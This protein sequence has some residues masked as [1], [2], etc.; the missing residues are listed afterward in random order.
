MADNYLF[1]FVLI[2]L[3]VFNY[4]IIFIICMVGAGW[5]NYEKKAGG[6]G[7]LGLETI[8]KRKKET[9]WLQYLKMTTDI[10]WCYY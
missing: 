6:W 9:L 7:I 10:E 3:L 1:I 4:S 2:N 8:M 5:N